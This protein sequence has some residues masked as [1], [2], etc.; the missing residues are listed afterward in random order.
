MLFGYLFSLHCMI[1]SPSK[2]VKRSDVEPIVRSFPPTDR[3]TV[4]G[5]HRPSRNRDFLGP[6]GRLVTVLHFRIQVHC[7]SGHPRK[8]GW[9]PPF[10]L[11]VS[12]LASCDALHGPAG[13]YLQGNSFWLELRTAGFGK[14]SVQKNFFSGWCPVFFSRTLVW[15]CRP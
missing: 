9:F 15:S 12:C 3:P 10:G 6:P 8:F 2:T 7:C 13:R 1:E 4:K 11:A 14:E 5:R